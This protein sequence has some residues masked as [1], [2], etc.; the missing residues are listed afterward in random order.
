MRGSIGI[1]NGEKGWGVVEVED[2][3]VCGSTLPCLTLFPLVRD[4]SRGSEGS[5]RIFAT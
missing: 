4:F 1:G 2:S 3:T 5:A